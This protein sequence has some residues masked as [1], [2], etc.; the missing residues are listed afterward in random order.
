MLILI[1]Y[2]RE[3][4]TLNIDDADQVSYN[5]NFGLLIF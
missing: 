5:L 4:F 1:I 3:I 2:K